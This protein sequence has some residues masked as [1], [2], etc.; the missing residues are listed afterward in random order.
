[1]YKI[2]IYSF[3]CILLPLA[4]QSQA[5]FNYVHYDT[6]D[7]LAGST[8]YSMA[9]DK[10]G[11]IWLATENGL[12]RYDGT[13]FKNF[14][15]K[16]GLPDNEVL[17]VF[18]DSRGR[19]WIATFNKA[20]SY[21]YNGKIYNTTNDS[22]VQRIK[23]SNSIQSI[24][25]NAEG[26]V[27]F[28]DSHTIL[29]LRADNSVFVISDLP[30]FRQWQ[31][32]FMVSHTS[33][34]DSGCFIGEMHS[35]Y[36]YGKGQITRLFSVRRDVLKE[37]QCFMQQNYDGTVVPID[38]PPN[39]LMGFYRLESDGTRFATID[40][41]T[42]TDGCWTVDTANKRLADH[43]LPG[44]QVTG[45]I[46]DSE[47]NTWFS[48]FGNGAYKL[49][50]KAVKTLLPGKKN[51]TLDTEIFSIAKRGSQLL[52]GSGLSTL[53]MTDRNGKL[54]SKDFSRQ[55]KVTGYTNVYN[56]I[57]S[58]KTLPS[59]VTFYGCDMFLLKET[60]N[61]VQVNTLSPVKSISEI[62][63]D[64]ILVACGRNVTT[65][66]VGDFRVTDTIWYER[67]TKAVF[68]N[69]HYYI[70]TLNGLYEVN[71]LKQAVY[72]G[73]IHHALTRRITDL[74]TDAGGV[75]WVATGDEGVV[76]YRDGRVIAALK[77]TN[78]LSSNICKT[79]FTGKDFLWVGTNKGINKINITTPGYTV[80]RYSTSD[81]L[82][83]DVINSLCIEDS[84]VWV[85]SPAGLTFFNEREVSGTSLCRLKLLGVN[86]S[87]QIQNINSPCRIPYADNNI[88]FDYIAISLKS[89]GD[90]TYYYRLRGFNA[91]WITTTQTSLTYQSLPP[92]DYTLEL[93]AIN[94]FGV[95]SETV[96]VPFSIVTPF[97][98]TWWFYAVLALFV[99]L[100]TIFL[101]NLRNKNLRRKLEEK[102]ILQKQFAAL[103]QQAL[104][105][106]MNPHFIFNCLNSIQQYILTNDKE[107]ANKYLTGFASLMRQTLDNSGKK[108]ITVAD[109][110]RYLR[111]YIEMERMRFGDTF[112]YKISVDD[113]LRQD[114][115]EMPAM[116]LQPYVENALRHGIRYKTD[117]TGR[118][119]INFYT[120]N[121]YLCC[122]IKDNGVG[123][124][125]TAALKSLQH[126]E[127]QSKGMSLTQKRV[128][129]LNRMTD[130]VITTAV[131]DLKDQQGHAAGTEVVVR[132]P[133]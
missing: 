96:Q 48:T 107:K 35:V 91:D 94:K 16:D 63:A 73:N 60:G 127:Y 113:N 71:R 39:T 128:E 131:I 97:W 31:K 28:N 15:V 110:V 55:R 62:N 9:Q 19:V 50:S 124:E 33:T 41:F 90:I 122:S 21:Y 79:L 98:R 30:I 46:T 49:P 112:T 40:Y 114:Y 65:V 115:T 120:E 14:T 27:I 58:I 26:A 101:F 2:L 47:N 67:G 43:F 45:L 104:Q 5:T 116:L 89:G 53:F 84:I 117:G 92:G 121:G 123:R 106:Q 81:G 4:G 11:F 130:E 56:R 52:A 54:T 78:G 20:L 34:K 111:Q 129:L 3:C 1:M 85:G 6:K 57:I 38:M 22:T 105:S 7:G 133:L 24:A 61:Q 66:S 68:H 100:L 95:R 109:E 74:Q 18:A 37:G 118:L 76:G 44:I 10:E 70:G 75:L 132:I 88:S 93:Y 125:K 86:S 82:P 36:K 77:D 103:E 42:T 12:S 99:L 29:E 51:N 87:G 80:T 119:D 59:G 23:L 72:L 69:N 25:E 8:V 108:A 102:N 17:K 83:S 13:N 126:I 64:T 32:S